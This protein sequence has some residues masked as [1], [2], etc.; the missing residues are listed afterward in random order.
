M[1]QLVH[2]SAAGICAFV[3]FFAG[4]V[5]MG[6]LRD[7]YAASLRLKLLEVTA[8]R[9]ELK[10]ELVNLNRHYYD[11]EHALDMRGCEVGQLRAQVL[12]LKGGLRMV[13]GGP[14]ESA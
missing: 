3:A 7:A 13:S 11:L 8:E 2:L 12:R 5:L 1:N 9:N 10:T 4:A 14:G 6:L